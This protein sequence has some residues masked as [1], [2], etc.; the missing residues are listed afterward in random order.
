MASFSVVVREAR[1]TLVKNR[2]RSTTTLLLLFCLAA[3]GRANA[4]NLLQFVRSGEGFGQ[5]IRV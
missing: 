5:K 2:I 3:A 1:A 4:S